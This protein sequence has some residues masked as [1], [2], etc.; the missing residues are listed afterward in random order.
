MVANNRGITDNISVIPVKRLDD[1]YVKEYY[2]AKREALLTALEKKELPPPCN[3]RESWGGKRCQSYCD[4][5][6]F[7]DVGRKARQ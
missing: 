7:C 2:R 6:E 5:R 3:S 1:S 4:V